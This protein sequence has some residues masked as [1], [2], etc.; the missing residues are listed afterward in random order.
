MIT[1]PSYLSSSKF[2]NI[3]MQLIWPKWITT[4]RHTHMTKALTGGSAMVYNIVLV[5]DGDVERMTMHNDASS[6]LLMEQ[7]RKIEPP[8]N[9]LL[10]KN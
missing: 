3:G 10:N 9:I 1:N 4:A 2:K 7:G 8:A 5:A 6:F